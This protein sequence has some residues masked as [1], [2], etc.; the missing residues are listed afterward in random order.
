MWLTWTGSYVQKALGDSEE[1]RIVGLI[2]RLIS[3]VMQLA[4][5]LTFYHW[6]AMNQ[7]ESAKWD[8]GQGI[9]RACDAHF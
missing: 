6:W 7:I 4:S 9:S 5:S 2:W 1:K 8:A 3:D